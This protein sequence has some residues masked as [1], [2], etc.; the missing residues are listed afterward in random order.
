M[1]CIPSNQEQYLKECMKE[2][3]DE[4]VNFNLKTTDVKDSATTSDDTEKSNHDFA[5]II[6]TAIRRIKTQME[7]RREA[8]RAREGLAVAIKDA[9][10]MPPFCRFSVSCKPDL[11]QAAVY[12]TIQEMWSSRA[13]ELRMDLIK[14]T[15]TVLDQNLDEH[16]K[17]LQEILDTTRDRI[18]VATKSAGLARTEFTKRVRKIQEDQEKEI[19]QFK[20]DIRSKNRKPVHKG[21]GWQRRPKPY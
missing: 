13:E 7:Q 12:K 8:V 5:E 15:I 17:I 20:T 1:D 14:E 4:M 11:K 9:N 21:N 2:D 18:G 6:S 16:N 10:F 19:L 3:E